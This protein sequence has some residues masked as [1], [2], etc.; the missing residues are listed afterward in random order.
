LNKA[1]H[2][3]AWVILP[4]HLHCVRTL[5]PGDDDFTNRWRLIKQGFSKALPPTERRSLV[6][7]YALPVANAACGNAGL[8]AHDPRRCGLRGARG[9]CHI[10]PVKHGYVQRVADWPHSTFHRHVERGIYPLNW[11]GGP[12]IDGVVGERP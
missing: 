8:G 6:R 12:D 7:I 4:D 2:I 11:A 10:N 1:F 3:D 9:Y 5:P